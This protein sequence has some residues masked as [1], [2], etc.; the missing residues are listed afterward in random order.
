MEDIPRTIAVNIPV[1]PSSYP[2]QD[3]SSLS[4]DHLSVLTAYDI[5]NALAA[6][7]FLDDSAPEGRY[8][9]GWWLLGVLD[10]GE[11]WW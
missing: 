6:L 9:S 3:V 8:E 5:F 10:D 7:E 2:T 1:T 11:L 4:T